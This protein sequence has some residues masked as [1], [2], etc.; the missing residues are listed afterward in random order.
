MLA[1]IKNITKL[2]LCNIY[3]LNVFRFSKDKKLRGKSVKMIAI[4]C[5]IVLVL[6]LYMG[7]LSYGLIRMGMENIVPAYLMAIASLLIF[8]FSILKAGAVIFR[9]EGYDILCSLPIRSE[10]IV[11]S[12]FLRLYIENMIF[13]LAVLLPGFAVY[14]WFVKPGILFYLCGFL[15]ILAVPLV[16]TAAAAITGALVAGISLRMKHKSLAAAGLSILAVLV[17]ML[18]SSKLSMEGNLDLEMLAELSSIILGILEKVYPPAVKF[19]MAVVNGNVLQ[20]LLFLLL[21]F[22][23]YSAVI[24]LISISFHFICQKLFT[25]SAKHN[26][27]MGEL[28]KGSVLTA[29]CRR[30][31]KRYFSSSIYVINTILG[32]IMGTIFSGVLLFGNVSQI[33]GGLPEFIDFGMLVP[34]VLGSVFCI[35]TTTSTSISLEGRKWWIVKSLPLTTK[36]ILDAKILMNLGLMLPFYIIS[37]IMLILALKPGFLDML[38]LLAAPAVICLF[39][40]VYGITINLHFPVLNWESEV[41]VVKQSA[42]A[43]IGGL[44]GFLTA[45][46]CIIITIIIPKQYMGFWKLIICVIIL[47]IT[48]VLYKK[49][50][51]IDLQEIE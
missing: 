1:Q 50:N 25:T 15:E 8:F 7:E 18:A 29:L 34:L 49:N 24:I 46:L 5:S 9:K 26:Y 23:I 10:A 32:P 4:G 21:F 6:L 14:A 31:F 20:C 47:A 11:F 2:E 13:A 42:S 37:E 44:G 28:K 39:S 40:C 36:S 41:S 43:L 27:K 17:I 3:G 51:Q 16:P 22:G 35:M 38:W 48:A 19:G 33:T 45:V 30:E 12:R